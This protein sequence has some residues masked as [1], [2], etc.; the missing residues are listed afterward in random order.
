ML[1]MLVKATNLPLAVITGSVEALSEVMFTRALLWLTRTLSVEQHGA[2]RWKRNTS[3]FPFPS[4]SPPM[5][6]ASVS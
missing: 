3:A 4:V 2:P 6:V 1:P 5:F